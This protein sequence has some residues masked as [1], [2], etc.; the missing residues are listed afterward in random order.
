MGL[1]RVQHQQFLSVDVLF[2]IPITPVSL[3]PLRDTTAAKH[4]YP[5]ECEL[6]L[7]T[8]P[9]LRSWVT[10]WECKLV[11][12]LRRTSGG[13]FKNRATIWLDGITD[14][15][16]MSLSNVWEMVMD[17]KAC[18]AAVHGVI[19]SQTQLS[20]STELMWSNNPT[21]GHVP[22]ENHNSKRGSVFTEAQFAIS[23]TWK[24][25]K[26]PQQRNG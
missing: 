2:S 23:R 15:M 9:P 7:C 8:L 16:D 25:P 22:R 18:C 3:C 11:W 4:P 10:R 12:P 19:K 26:C 13:S 20:N 14:S 17:K 6:Q 1:F 21:P 24:Q 5:S